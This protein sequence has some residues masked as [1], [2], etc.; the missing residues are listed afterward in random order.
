MLKF[1]K[2]IT[3]RV[4]KQPFCRLIPEYGL[5][6]LGQVKTNERFC[7]VQLVCKKAGFRSP[8]LHFFGPAGLHVWLLH[9][10]LL[11]VFFWGGSCG[12]RAYLSG[13][14]RA[15]EKQETQSVQHATKCL[16]RSNP[17]P[18]TFPFSSLKNFHKTLILA[19]VQDNLINH[20]GKSR[21]PR[22]RQRP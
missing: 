7:F 14:I 8:G 18:E 3:F 16:A 17:K 21:K 11:H 4:T 9:V 13:R 6:G 15:N 1:H 20:H 22:S 10:A 12:V 5:S 2:A 19:P